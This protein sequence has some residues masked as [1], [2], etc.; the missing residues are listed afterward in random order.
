MER[1]DDA[2]H[3]WLGRVDIDKGGEHTGVV[4]KL[5]DVAPTEEGGAREKG[6]TGANC[7]PLEDVRTLALRK[8]LRKEGQWE[9]VVRVERA[10][11]ER[12]VNEPANTELMEAGMGDASV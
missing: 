9:S 11:A 5:D 7:L 3:V 2:R 4:L 8:K 12:T 1:V 10:A 6:R